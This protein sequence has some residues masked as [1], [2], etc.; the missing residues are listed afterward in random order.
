MISHTGKRSAVIALAMLNASGK[1]P[2]PFRPFMRLVQSFHHSSEPTAVRLVERPPDT[3]WWATVGDRAEGV[4]EGEILDRRYFWGLDLDDTCTRALTL[5][6][7]RE[8]T[9]RPFAFLDL[10]DVHPV[11]RVRRWRVE[12]TELYPAGS[13]VGLESEADALLH[14]L[15]IARDRLL[16]RSW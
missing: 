4:V 12:G 1:L 15:L 3:R 7:I 10:V 5:E 6:I 2:D 14:A 9:A 16:V 8:L 13:R 11:S